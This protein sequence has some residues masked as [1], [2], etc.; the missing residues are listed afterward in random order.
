[1]IE[2]NITNEIIIETIELKTHQKEVQALFEASSEFILLT[3]GKLPSNDAAVEYFSDFPPSKTIDDKVCL[4]IFNQNNHLIG[5]VDL[6]YNYPDENVCFVGLFLIHPDFR[7][8]KVGKTVFSRI[9]KHIKNEGFN[10]I[11]LAVVK[12]NI[13]GYQFW[14]KINYID[15]MKQPYQVADRTTEI[16]VM[17]KKLD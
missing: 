11:R 10:E 5:I 2:I 14:K 3:E 13:K 15:L 12:E 17:N 1:M 16:L 8:E 7:S 6:I 9:E 4:G